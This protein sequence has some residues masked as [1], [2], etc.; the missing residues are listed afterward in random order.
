MNFPSV[1]V[2]GGFLKPFLLLSASLTVKK[3]NGSFS[4]PGKRLNPK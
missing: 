2:L 4:I 1:S 3:W